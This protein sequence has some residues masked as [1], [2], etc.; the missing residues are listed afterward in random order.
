MKGAWAYSTEI[1]IQCFSSDSLIHLSNGEYKKISKLKSGDKILTMDQS[2]II[3][4]EMIM[5][6]HKHKSEKGF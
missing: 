1:K 3:S 6:L 5:M 2:N 4:T